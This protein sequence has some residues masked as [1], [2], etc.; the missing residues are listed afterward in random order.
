MKQQQIIVFID[1]NV[2]YPYKLLKLLN[3]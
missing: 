3:I 1:K 2:F